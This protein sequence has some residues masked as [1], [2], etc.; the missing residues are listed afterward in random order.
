M[1]KLLLFITVVAF[2]LK[3]NAQEE[4]KKIKIELHGYV[5]INA[6]FDS[7]QS[8]TARNGNIYLWPL[9]PSLDGSGQDLNSASSFDIDAAFS[10][11]NL[12]VSG[13]DIWGAKTIAFVEGDFLGDKAQGNDLYFRLRHAF[14]RLNWEK[15]S[16]LFG[17]Y[18]HPLFIP[19][20]Y[21]SAVTLSAGSPYHPLNRQPMLRY[22]YK[23]SDKLEVL[24]FLMSQ[25]DF[26]DRGMT[27][28]VENS[29]RPEIDVQLKYN[30]GDFFA[31]FT[32]GY[33]TL[34]PSLLDPLNGLKTDELAQAG[35]FAGS[36]RQK[37][38]GFTIKAE[39]I[40]GGAMSNLVM[41]GGFAEKN[42]GSAQ[43]QYTPINTMALWTDIQTNHKKIQPGIFAGYTKNL[44]ASEEA[45]YLSEY[46]LG[47]TIGEMYTISPRIKFYATQKV[48]LGIE[49][50]YAVAGYGSD[51]DE[52][53]KPINLENV[54]NHRITTMLKYIF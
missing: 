46:T 30:N 22:E 52:N 43:R 47:G 41:L 40:Y 39:G 16:I 19:E 5:G 12:G 53:A 27:N 8:A 35:Y 48:C 9:P 49:W 13:P 45:N 11:V 33:K 7:R 6:F 37:F 54:T 17:Q 20:N 18:W 1:K 10:R 25:N 28:A 42:N 50:M 23:M 26:S 51:F 24:A 3:I 31:A 44:G 14:I 38:Q 4:E 32:A 34:K 2:A 36:I 29:L 21:P 15:S